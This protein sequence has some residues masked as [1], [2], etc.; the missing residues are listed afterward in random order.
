MGYLLFFFS[1]K[2]TFGNNVLFI[3]DFMFRGLA[4]FIM[5][6]FIKLCYRTFQQ[7]TELL[8]TK[9]TYLKIY[10]H[11]M[12]FCLVAGGVYPPH[13]H[14]G[15]TTKKNTFFMCVFPN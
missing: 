5:H 6:K 7:L 14:S 3:V 2:H 15:P 9:K 4:F 11:I 8:N 13:T 12:F 10:L 1:R